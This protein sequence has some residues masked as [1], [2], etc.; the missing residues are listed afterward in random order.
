M[1][2]IAQALRLAFAAAGVPAPEILQNCSDRQEAYDSQRQI[3]NRRFQFM[4]AAIV[5]CTSAEQVSVVVK[6]IEAERLTLR[7]RSG[8]HDHEGECSGTDTVL[9][10]FRKMNNVTIERAAGVA[11][12]EPGNVFQKLTTNLAAKDVMIPHGTCATVGI[13]GFSLGGGWGPWTRKHGMCCERVV[14]ATLVLGDGSIKTITEQDEL[15]QR[16]LLWAIKGGGG[17]SY[18]IVTE[19]VIKTFPLPPLL[20]KF[21]V[22]WNP[23]AFDDKSL[24][25]FVEGETPT[26]KVLTAWE[27][28]IATTDAETN[29]L[30][31]TNLKISA[32]PADEGGPFDPRTVAHNCIMYGYWSGA[33]TGLRR[34][35]DRAF[36][37]TGKYEFKVLGKGGS[38]LRAKLGLR[39]GDH[40]MSSWDRFSHAEFMAKVPAKFH[41]LLPLRF[42]KLALK[43]KPLPPDVDNP[44]P[45]KI[46]S[47]F[48]DAAGLGPA[49]HAALLQSLTSPLVLPGNHWLGLF[50]Y[51]TLG[52]MTGE[53]Y[54]NLPPERQAA[55]AF[56]YKDKLYTIQYQ[57]WW[58]DEPNDV[59]HGSDNP[60]YNRVNRAL[61]WME[62]CRDYAIPNTSGAF[63]SFKDSSV[64]TQKY[65]A[66]SYDELV[67]I[68]QRDA[69]DPQ[70]HFRSRKT[71]I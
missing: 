2:S 40:L 68:K 9:I 11:R 67:K 44:A 29:Q 22:E 56:P 63:I 66:E 60:V 52:A 62:V 18:G 42:R 53:F 48:V 27:R 47:R 49:G 28:L 26:I 57:T 6:F 55:S 25:F 71:I 21:Q 41:H 65:F 17:F 58:N 7:V 15:Q 34:L 8:G 3:F 30:I 14:G 33:E 4:P 1:S 36:R 16:G 20:I 70:N 31:G 12:I 35:L 69:K 19:F 50:S 10:D 54:Q 23:H 59:A 39:Y 13:A 5:F 45:H 32:K 24:H 46:T 43:G 51:I 37:G 61:D 38:G 64:T